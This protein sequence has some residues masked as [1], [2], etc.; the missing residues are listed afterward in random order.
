MNYRPKI[1]LI[2]A[3]LLGLMFYGAIG[4]TQAKTALSTE[5]SKSATYA[6]K[7]SSSNIHIDDIVIKNSTDTHSGN[8]VISEEEQKRLVSK[9]SN[10]AQ[11]AFMSWS[12]RQGLFISI[13]GFTAVIAIFGAMWAWMKGEIERRIEKHVNSLEKKREEA[14]EATIKANHEIERTQKKL[15]ELQD[16]ENDLDKKLIDFQRKTNDEIN[17]KENELVELRAK[18]DSIN[19]NLD[20]ITK[21]FESKTTDEIFRLEQKIKALERIIDKIDK[22]EGAKDLV[23]DELIADLKSNDKETKYSAAELLPQFKLNSN[24]I[25]EA[26]VERLKDKPD[27]T[28]GSLLLSGLGELR[29]DGNTLAYLFDL[30]DDISN[31]NIL[32][33]IGALG[34]LGELGE[35][36]INDKELES[37]VDKLLSILDSDLDHKEFSDDSITASSVKGAIA[38]AL[39]YYGDKAEKAVKELISLLADQDQETRKNA[40]IAL[41]KIGAKA[42]DAIPSIQKLKDDEYTEVRDAASDAI[43]G[44]QKTA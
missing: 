27:I 37:I 10:D 41:G 40:T 34:E 36:K 39:S 35:T 9:L 44:I 33:I 29:V 28:F 17:I 23:V 8:S 4:Y 6:E 7:T 38:L 31:P 13:F 26:F 12:K 43:E 3:L 32:A 15:A 5:Q 25:T 14:I 24:K 18:A 20:S 30:V 22:D 42:K 2:F 21:G 19:D 1:L 11:E 16:I